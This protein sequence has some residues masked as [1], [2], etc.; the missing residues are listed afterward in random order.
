LEGF[1]YK[2][3]SIANIKLSSYKANELVYESNSSSEQLAVFSEIY[4]KDG[5]NAYV[6]GQ[7]TPHIRVNYVLRAMRIPGGKHTITFKFEPAIYA[8]GEKISMAC[9]ALLL[10][11]VAGIGLLECRK[12]TV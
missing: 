8:T 12:K 1:Q 4:Y 2:Y 10:L 6:D 5:W 3:D 11:S 7:L 9:S